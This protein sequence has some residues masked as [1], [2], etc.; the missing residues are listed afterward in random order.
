M[1]VM[2][3]N[4]N[5]RV[6]NSSFFCLVYLV[7]L[8]G[9]MFFSGCATNTPETFFTVSGPDWH[10]RQGQALWTPKM[11]ASQF[12]GDLVLA[13]DN[14]GRS[15]VQFDK[16]PLSLVT[17][18]LTTNQWMLRFPQFNNAFYKGHKPATT[19]AVFLYLP[20]AIAGKSLPKPLSFEQKAD[21]SW[22][23][24]NPKTGESVEGFLSP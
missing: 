22:K 14:N 17:V 4:K 12:G 1:T 18:Q 5:M 2:R 15:F 19:R 10:V 21:G 6:T 20:D 8:T 16:M 13:T 7:L 3:D 11:G 24:A 9:L 23:L